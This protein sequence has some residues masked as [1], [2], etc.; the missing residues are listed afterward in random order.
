MRVKHHRCKADY[1]RTLS[2]VVA[3][4]DETWNSSQRRTIGLSTA[5]NQTARHSCSV[6]CTTYTLYCIA[7]AHHTTELLHGDQ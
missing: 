2:V 6:Y 1:A 3:D 7:S 4:D 5:S